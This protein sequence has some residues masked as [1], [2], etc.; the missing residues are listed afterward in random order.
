MKKLLFC[1]ALI[2]APAPCMAQE[3]LEPDEAPLVAA[4][5]PRL[6]GLDYG[7]KL[8][9]EIGSDVRIF[10]VVEGGL[11]P[12]FA[13]GL[14]TARNSYRIFMI[15]E[16]RTDRLERCEAPIANDLAIDII[17]AWDKVLRQAHRRADRLKGGADVP[18]FH[19][20]S[21]LP[22]GLVM[23]RV[24]DTPPNSNPALLARIAGGLLQVCSGGRVQAIP[25][26]LAEIRV[27]LGRIHQ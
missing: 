23:G 14:K 21:R 4:M 6:Y 18:F 25:E 7:R 12:D 8:K 16:T 3:N 11:V 22:S 17:L 24:W 20:G 10:A 27:A 26:A 19:F 15:S 13:V 1:L 2:F 9:P 5:P